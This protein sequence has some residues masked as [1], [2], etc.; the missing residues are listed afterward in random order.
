MG[1]NLVCLHRFVTGLTLS[2]LALWNRMGI[3]L[4]ASKP[5]LHNCIVKDR[6][7]LGK[8]KVV[9]IK[10]LMS[11]VFSFCN[12]SIFKKKRKTPRIAQLRYMYFPCARAKLNLLR[13]YQHTGRTNSWILQ[14]H[15][16]NFTFF[17]RFLIF[18][19]FKKSQNQLP[20]AQLQYM[21]FPCAR[22]ELNSLR[23][24][25]DTGRTNSWI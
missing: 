21:C 8:Y 15:I 6:E 20:V 24:Y 16:R 13:G 19:I 1:K 11:Q 22:G 23:G 25:G 5:V 7:I 10:V 14:I 9:N 12:F 2:K 4:N 17:Q 18:L 3:Q